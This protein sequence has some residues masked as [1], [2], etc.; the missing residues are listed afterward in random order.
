MGQ[1]VQWKD[2]VEK[3]AASF[4]AECIQLIGEKA[5]QLLNRT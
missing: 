3:N 1:D 5:V 4:N 2:C